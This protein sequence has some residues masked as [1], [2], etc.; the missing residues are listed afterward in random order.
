MPYIALLTDLAAQ[1]HRQLERTA[2]VHRL[3]R[4]RRLEAALDHIHPREL[5]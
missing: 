5:P 2:A 1:R 3:V 4:Q